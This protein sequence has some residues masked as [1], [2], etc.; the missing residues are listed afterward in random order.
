MI[1]IFLYGAITFF[2]YVSEIYLHNLTF[3]AI[4]YMTH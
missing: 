1:H 3:H 2:I 4:V